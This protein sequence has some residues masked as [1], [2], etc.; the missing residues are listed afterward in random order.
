MMVVC[1]VE[2]FRTPRRITAADRKYEDRREPE[3]SEM[4]YVGIRRRNDDDRKVVACAVVPRQTYLCMCQ[5]RKD[6]I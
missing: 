5:R 1:S 6:L 2:R 3:V 4:K